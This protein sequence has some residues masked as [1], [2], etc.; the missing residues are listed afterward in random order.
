MAIFAYT[1]VPTKKED[2]I[3]IELN[4]LEACH[5][6]PDFEPKRVHLYNSLV[7]FEEVPYYEVTCENIDKCRA[8]LEHL[9]KEVKKDGNK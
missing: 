5:K 2:K 9:K 8:L 4:V 3:V 1:C 7:N 6:C